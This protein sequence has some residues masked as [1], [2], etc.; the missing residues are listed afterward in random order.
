MNGIITF[1]IKQR[2]LVLIFLFC[3]LG[4]GFVSFLNLNIEAYPDPVPPLVEVITQATG[5]SAE[6]I[7]RYFTIPIEVQLNG[8][9]NIKAIRSISLFGL[10]DIKVQFTYDFTFEEAQQR[11][12]NRL[13]QPQPAARRG[14]A[15]A[16]AHQ[17]DRRNLPLPAGRPA[18]LFGARPQ[19]AAGLGARPAVPGGSRR[20]RRDGLGR[21]DQDL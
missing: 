3:V 16:L 18:R 21:Q 4:G 6:E 12:I 19:D 15:A 13:S 17:P 2:V 14:H 20:H 11:V 9:P 1:S 8:I 7:E 5:Q 10:S